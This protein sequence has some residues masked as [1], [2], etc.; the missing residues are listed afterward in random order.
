MSIVDAQGAVVASYEY[1]PYGNLISDEPAE[2]T[3]GHLNPIRYR[4]YYYDSESELYY[5]Q[6]RYYDP[7]IGRFLNADAFA[8]TGQGL[9]GNNMFA[10]CGNNPITRQDDGGQL[11]EII[12]GAALGGAI[13]GA[14]V[15]TVSYLVTSGINGNEVTAAGVLGAIATGAVTGAIG[16]VAG[17]LGGVYA[18]IGSVIVGTISG[19][20]TAHNTDGSTEQKIAAGFTAGVVATL[21][22]YLGTKIPVALDDGFS[23]GFTSFGGGLFMGTQTEVVNVVTQQIVS[24]GFGSSSNAATVI[25]KR[26]IVAI[27][28]N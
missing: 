19:V 11:W 10:Y 12:V 25:Q 24:N 28:L 5:L 22:T 27:V 20:V 7:D 9:L 23:T 15:G 3:V 14:I 21:G 26:N 18:V 8:S 17:A 6:S 1:D 16:A 13:A 2:N 4:G